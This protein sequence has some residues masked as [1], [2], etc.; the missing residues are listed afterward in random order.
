MAALP[1]VRRL[2][3][4]RILKH[5]VRDHLPDQAL[6]PAL[7][8]IEEIWFDNAETASHADPYLAQ[9]EL[10]LNGSASV[11]KVVAG[12]AVD[13][14]V[15]FSRPAPPQPLHKR[16]SLL[17]RRQGLTRDAFHHYWLTVHAP[18]ASCHRHVARYTQN[19]LVSADGM[20]KAGSCPQIDGVG[21]FFIS[22]IQGMQDD[23]QTPEGQRMND[24]SKNFIGSVSTYFV[25]PQEFAL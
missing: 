12:Y 2:V 1:G 13:E 22:D 16:I 5:V 20:I 11:F 6:I 18:F 24:D 3:R 8:G 19:H 23:Y 9:S 10:G 7:A 21:E 15:V 17:R 25:T 4:N 14:H